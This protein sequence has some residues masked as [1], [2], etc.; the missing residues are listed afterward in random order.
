MEDKTVTRA[1]PKAVS[2][3]IREHKNAR[4]SAHLNKILLWGGRTWLALHMLSSG[5]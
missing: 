2:F 3:I 5:F 4:E 1:C